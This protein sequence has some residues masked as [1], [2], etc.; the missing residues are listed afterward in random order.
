MDDL[1]RELG[2]LALAS[3]L[4]RLSER[5][6]RDV[7]HIYHDHGLDFEARWFG[8]LHFLKRHPGR[9]VTEVAQALGLTHPAINQLAASLAKHRLLR[10]RADPC[11][12]RRR[13]LYLTARA[14]RLIAS[15]QP[16]WD[17]VRLATDQLLQQSSRDFL[18]ALDKIENE[19]DEQSMY[20]RLH[21]RVKE[22]LEA[23]GVGGKRKS[24]G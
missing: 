21:R 4:R 23:K 20:E 3:R 1:I 17:D 10:S 11:D 8:M 15:L 13:L 12:G 19:L 16:I 5:L 6:M 14:D 7:T 2:S 24:A 22:R 18:S 9:P